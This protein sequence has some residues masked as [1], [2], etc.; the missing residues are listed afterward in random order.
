[1]KDYYGSHY[2]QSTARDKEKKKKNC[3]DKKRNK[4][5]HSSTEY[6]ILIASTVKTLNWI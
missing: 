3:C 4:K 1:M 6:N 2:S 5:T